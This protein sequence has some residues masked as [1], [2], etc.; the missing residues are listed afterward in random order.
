MK[1]AFAAAAFAVLVTACIA[2]LT[3]SPS[4]AGA[5]A[6]GAR[7][8]EHSGLMVSVDSARVRVPKLRGKKLPYA[9]ILIRRAGL[10]VGREDCDCTFGVVIKSSWYVCQQWPRAGKIVGRRARVDTYSVRDMVDC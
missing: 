4:T 8:T 5:A 9:E 7:V 1:R 3:M 6:R 10:R 2:L